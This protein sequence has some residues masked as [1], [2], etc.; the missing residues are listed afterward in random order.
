M[1]NRMFDRTIGIDYSGGDTAMERLGGLAVYCVDGNGLPQRVTPQALHNPPQRNVVRWNRREI[2]EWLVEQLKKEGK[3]T[4]VGIDHAFSFPIDYFERYDLPRPN[5]G[6][7]LVDFQKHWPTDGNDTSVADIRDGTGQRRRGETSWLRLTDRL[8]GT[9]MSVFRFGV[10]GQ[11]ATSTHAGLPWL[12]YIRRELRDRVHFWPFDGWEIPKG[13]S[14]IA[15]VYPAL[16]KRRFERAADMNDHQHDAYS[17]AGWLSHM[18]Q[19]G[20]L[21]EY[22]NPDLS[23]TERAQADAEGWILGVQGFIRLSQ[24]QAQSDGNGR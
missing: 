24:I 7:F 15:E 3:P 20:L 1:V 2:A 18:D 14:V 21:G 22:F 17:V 9:A 13:K 6:H 23:P 8:T 12:L 10:Q 5:W 4:L 16:W 11:V 19:N